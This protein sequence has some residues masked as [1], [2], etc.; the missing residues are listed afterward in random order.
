MFTRVLVALALIAAIASRADALP[1][2]AAQTGQPCQTCHIGSF[3]PQLTPFGREFKIEGYTMT[4]GEGLA[5]KIPTLAMVL[6]SFTNTAAAQPEGAA[7]HFGTNNNFAVDQVSLFF[8]GRIADFAG[9][10]VQGTYSGV[11]RA[12]LLDNTDFKLTTPLSL[13][14]TEL[15]IGTWI[16]NGPTVQ[17][18]FNSTPVWMFPFAT[19]ALAPTPTAQTLLG[20][21]QLVGNSL[22]SRPTAGTTESSILRPVVT[23]PMAQPY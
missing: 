3:G 13:N 16:N 11:D 6:G 20:G 17:D 2:F 22:G 21:R 4:G 12:F 15:R 7:P 19:S 1:S 8:A 18:P 23:E 10:F 14:D 9:A 5:S